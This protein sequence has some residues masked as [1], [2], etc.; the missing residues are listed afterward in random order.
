MHCSGT[1]DCTRLLQRGNTFVA[2][3]TTGTLWCALLAAKQ[4]RSL[5]AARLGV[6]ACLWDGAFVLTAFF[7]TQP[8]ETFTGSV[9]SSKPA[10]LQAEHD[11]FQLKGQL[12]HVELH[13][14]L[15]V[16]HLPRNHAPAGELLR[17]AVSVTSVQD[18]P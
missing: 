9:A 11:A 8:T 4:P 3:E 10:S 2:P 15:S 16:S 1:Y 18:N 14:H 7:L 5:T 6:G 17:S 13:H 12:L